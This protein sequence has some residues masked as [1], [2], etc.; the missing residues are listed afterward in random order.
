[1]AT[2]GHAAT[3]ARGT[4][5]GRGALLIVR[6]VRVRA[7]GLRSWRAVGIGRVVRGGGGG[8]GGDSVGRTVPREGPGVDRGPRRRRRRR[9]DLPDRGLSGGRRVGR[10]P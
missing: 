3:P 2:A 8:R 7:G 1:M 10:F 6:L 5:P 4:R 9:A